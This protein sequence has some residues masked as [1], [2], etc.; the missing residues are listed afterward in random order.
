M[1]ELKSKINPKIELIFTIL[2]ASL[3]LWI[4]LLN[5]IINE[6]ESNPANRFLVYLSVIHYLIFIVLLVS[7]VLMY[8][9]G[10][11]KI[12]SDENKYSKLKSTHEFLNFH[13]FKW[14]LPILM[15]SIIFLAY[16]LIFDVY[17]DNNIGVYIIL[18]IVIITILFSIYK[19]FK[20]SPKSS[21]SRNKSYKSVL[22]IVFGYFFYFIL[23]SSLFSN[24]EIETNKNYYIKSDKVLFLIKRSG[25]ILLPDVKKIRF[26]NVNT[27]FSD[28]NG[29]FMY[30][31]ILVDLNIY[32]ITSLDNWA[33]NYITV[34]YRDPL[35][36]ISKN[37]IHYLNIYNE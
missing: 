8:T 5:L 3:G 24:V 21:K 15:L 30:R 9:S 20:I 27:I 13:L 37:K 17:I 26:R 22:Y 16:G 2:T 35:F 34:Q 36:G 19:L 12:K 1:K 33:N 32:D 6:G 28:D 18:I 7:L 4:Y 10:L 11:S 29:N 25:Y 31:N 14:W 23:M